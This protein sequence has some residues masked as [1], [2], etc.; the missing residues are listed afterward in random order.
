MK[1]GLTDKQGA[2]G[3]PGSLSRTMDGPRI[4]ADWVDGA[5]GISICLVVLWHTA[6]ADLFVN[7]LLIF[8]RM[9]LFFF[10]AG[11]FA[12]KA[13]SGSWASLLKNRCLNYYYIYVVWMTIFFTMVVCVRELK[14][15][16]PPH[17]S[18]YLINFVLP[19]EYLWFIFALALLFA[20]AKLARLLPKP[21]VIG[22]L[23]LAYAV[24][25]ADGQ[26]EPLTFA[27]RMA[28][29]PLFFILGTYAFTAVNTH[30]HT[31]RLLWPVT[32]AAFLA[33]SATILLFDIDHLAPL[34][35]VASALGIFAVCQ[36]CQVVEGTAIGAGLGFIGRH[37]LYIYL[38][39]KILIVYLIN[40]FALMGLSGLPATPYLVFATALP[41]SLIG[42]LV[43]SRIAPWLFEAPWVGRPQSKI[44][45]SS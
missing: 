30:S 36:F 17:I 25:V 38:L 21:A 19:L 24:S 14:N 10:A 44:A 29:L 6:G 40:G 32:L 15:G 43:L 12:A 9:P 41:L 35:L 42:G 3:E 16:T 22:I 11:F 45:T 2:K 31:Y 5:K 18:D 39:H 26:W 1:P 37:T 20:V 8:V 7:T 23:L 33:L 4:R 27:T 28:R 34:T 13:I